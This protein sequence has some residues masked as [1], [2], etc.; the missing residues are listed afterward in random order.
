V[1]SSPNA[2][3]YSPLSYDTAF[4]SSFFSGRLSPLDPEPSSRSSVHSSRTTEF[5]PPKARSFPSSLV[6]CTLLW[7]KGI[8]HGLFLLVPPIFLFPPECSHRASS[9][10]IGSGKPFPITPKRSSVARPPSSKSLRAHRELILHT[11]S[12]GTSPPPPPGRV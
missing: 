4:F 6:L 3:S 5:P 8:F 1:D 7:R 10:R 2:L 9:R 12:S 11:R